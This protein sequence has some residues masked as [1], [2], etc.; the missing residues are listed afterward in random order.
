MMDNWGGMGSGGWLIALVVVAVIVV[1]VVAIVVA[2]RGQ[3]S[4]DLS[5]GG[6]PTPPS[7]GDTAEDV[8]KRRYASGEIGRDEYEQALR[9][10]RS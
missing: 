10:L 8:L 5:G 9:D 3:G 4:R 2:S 1:A 6:A 7:S